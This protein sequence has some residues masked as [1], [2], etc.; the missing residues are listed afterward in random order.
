MSVR[1]RP[2]LPW[3]G[4]A[5]AAFIGCVG[6]ARADTASAREALERMVHAMRGTDYTGVFVY[7]QGAD[8]LEAMRIVH[9]GGNGAERERL[10]S[11]TGVAREIVRDGDRVTC[12][13]PDS[14]SVMVDRRRTRN[15]LDSVLP[16]NLDRIGRHYRL[17]AS[18]EVRIAGRDAR[19]IHIEAGDAYR[20]GYRFWVDGATGLMLRADLVHGG[21]VL[22]QVMFTELELPE[23]IPEA[24]LKP[25][26]SGQGYTWYRAPEEQPERLG[27]EPTWRLGFVPSGF[28][29]R[30]SERRSMPIAGDEPVEHQLY[31]DGL[32]AISVYVSVLDD[33]EEPFDGLSRMGGMTAVGRVVD[34]HQVVVV[35]EVPMRAA[36]EVAQSLALEPG[37]ASP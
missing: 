32:T 9:R 26:F 16:D 1:S 12:I 4:V 31:S 13:L 8:T 29:L 24:W 22:E 33:D 7:R 34:G 36:V 3:I 35:G 18:G 19:R 20:Y 21:E 25:S 2:V 37:T 14:N 30:L 10:Y 5:L 28:E 6:Q 11:L 15:P 17:S 27:F 23:Q